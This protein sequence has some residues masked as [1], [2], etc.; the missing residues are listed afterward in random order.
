MV[1]FLDGPKV[2]G[3]AFLDRSGVA[4]LTVAGL[5]AGPHQIS[6]SYEGDNAFSSSVA[7]MD[8]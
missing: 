5:S 7:F 3:N 6:A 8:N 4:S 2:L 1:T